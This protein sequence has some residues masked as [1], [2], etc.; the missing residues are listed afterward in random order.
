MLSHFISSSSSIQPASVRLQIF[1]RPS[2]DF[3]LCILS[4]RS[5]SS[6][7]FPPAARAQ[8]HYNY[9]VL[10]YQQLP[11]SQQ[12]SAY[13]PLQLE[14]KHERELQQH[15]QHQAALAQSTLARLRKLNLRTYGAWCGWCWFLQ[16]GNSDANRRAGRRFWIRAATATATT[17]IRARMIRLC[18]RLWFIVKTTRIVIGHLALL[19][20][21]VLLLRLPLLVS[22]LILRLL[23]QR[24]LH[25]EHYWRC[26]GELVMELDALVVGC[27]DAYAFISLIGS[28]VNFRFNLISSVV[29]FQFNF[30]IVKWNFNISFG[31]HHNH[32]HDPGS[33]VTTANRQ[34]G[35]RKEILRQC[36]MMLNTR[37]KEFKKRRR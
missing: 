17:R 10:V 29:D 5:S 12:P 13:Q 11:Y 31:I 16:N 24:D 32:D 14:H 34:R 8:G 7:Y 36:D 37:R 18:R 6:F 2:A 23:L 3:V 25:A 21:L 19:L 4:S 27:D 20:L 15:S 30:F 22:L 26:W 1:P 28:I 33:I 35:I 9:H